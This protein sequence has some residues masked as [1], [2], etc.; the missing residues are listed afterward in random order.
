MREAANAD[1]ERLQKMG[2]IGQR[3]AKERHSIDQEA[4]K[5]AA[6]FFGDKA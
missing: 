6:L 5:L 4:G 1:P 2:E 3:R